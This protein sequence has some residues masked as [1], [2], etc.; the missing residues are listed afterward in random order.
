MPVNK[1]EYGGD[2]LIDLT[3]D[4]ATTS[5]VLS[6]YTFHDKTGAQVTGAVTFA[7]YYTGSGA[8]SS[9]LGANGDIY[10]QTS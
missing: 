8:P 9:S 2:S 5:E 3:G 7:T 6:G 4:T 1:I 10:L